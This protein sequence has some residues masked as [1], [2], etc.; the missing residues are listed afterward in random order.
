VNLDSGTS[1][2]SRPERQQ[3]LLVDVLDKHHTHS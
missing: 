1:C 3:V 2:S